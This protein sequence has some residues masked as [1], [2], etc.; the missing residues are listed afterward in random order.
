ML[1]ASAEMP[2]I[3]VW[4][5]M[6]IVRDPYSGAG[7]GKVTITAT[8]L[9]L[10]PLRAARRKPGEGN[11]PEAQPRPTR[12][13]GSPSSVGLPG[14]GSPSGRANYSSRIPIR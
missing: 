8:A 1:A 10:A 14:L 12:W 6:Q 3:H 11:S 9:G 7:A 2:K 4:D 5:A 13:H